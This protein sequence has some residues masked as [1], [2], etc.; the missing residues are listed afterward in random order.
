[1]FKSFTASAFAAALAITPITATPSLAWSEED[2]LAAV[3]F[4]AAALYIL[5]EA[6]DND[7]PVPVNTTTTHSHSHGVT[8]THAHSHSGH[9]HDGNHQYSQ[10]VLPPRC[11]RKT[12]KVGNNTGAH[13]TYFLESCLKKANATAGLPSQCKV[14]ITTPEGKRGAYAATC[15]SR[16]GYVISGKGA[17]IYSGGKPRYQ[18]GG[19]DIRAKVLPARCQRKT[20]GQGKNTG[21]HHTYLS[22]ECLEARNAASGLPSKCQTKFRTKNGMKSG[23]VSTCLMRHGYVVGHK[24]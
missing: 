19:D 9:A 18:E 5:S 15:L 1:M 24:R 22:S 16:H 11:Q 12:F 10:K 21:K 14:T 23:Y 20:V 2:T 17:P 6:N 8:H 3:I 13:Q 7:G 4:G